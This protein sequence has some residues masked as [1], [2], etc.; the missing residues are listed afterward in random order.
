VSSRR[1]LLAAGAL[2]L[3]LGG[4]LGAGCGGSDGGSSSTKAGFVTG[5]T[6]P[7]YLRTST[8]PYETTV[9]GTATMIRTDAQG[10][11]I[12]LT[13]TG[14][15]GGATPDTA[16]PPTAAT[17]AGDETGIRVPAVFRVE[18]GKLTPETVVKL[19]PGQ[20]AG[21]IK[22]TIDGQPAAGGLHVADDAG[23]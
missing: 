11:P 19:I 13:T 7:A 2:A 16:P 9:E 5:V 21:T 4:A 6:T 18:G 1:Q 17:S 23:P 3:A 15:T 22:V 20:K 10:N 8:G 14:S 12:P